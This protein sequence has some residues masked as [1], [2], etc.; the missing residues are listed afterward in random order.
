MCMFDSVIGNGCVSSLKKD[1]HRRTWFCH[2]MWPWLRGKSFSLSLDP[3]TRGHSGHILSEHS[4]LNALSREHIWNSCFISLDEHTQ[5]MYIFV[6]RIS[7]RH[8]TYPC[9]TWFFIHYMFFTTVNLRLHGP[10]PALSSLCKLVGHS[11]KAEFLWCVSDCCRSTEDVVPFKQAG[12]SI[13]VPAAEGTVSPACP[14]RML[15]WTSLKKTKKKEQLASHTPITPIIQREQWSTSKHPPFLFPWA[16]ALR[17]H[18]TVQLW[19]GGPLLD[20]RAV[21]RLFPGDCARRSHT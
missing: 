20:G 16:S 10:V 19:G 14:L 3:D 1:S 2:R 13:V 18:S 6:H 15:D 12:S 7:W 5:N 8:V 9:L 21:L 17:S 4:I 11:S